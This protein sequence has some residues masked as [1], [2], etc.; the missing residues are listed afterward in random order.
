V[1]I[2]NFGLAYADRKAMK[3]T[4]DYWEGPMVQDRSYI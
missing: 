4:T 3:F 1:Y 2:Q